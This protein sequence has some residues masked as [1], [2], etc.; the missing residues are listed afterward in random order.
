MFKPN[1][2]R[3]HYNDRLKDY[4]LLIRMLIGIAIFKSKIA[5]IRSNLV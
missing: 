3:M 4:L 1:L 5:V 2:T